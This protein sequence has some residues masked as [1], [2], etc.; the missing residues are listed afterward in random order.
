MI[1]D[2]KSSVV[3]DQL[4]PFLG[5]FSLYTKSDCIDWWWEPFI[6]GFF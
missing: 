2:V 4:Y 6:G 3:K 1:N 5:N